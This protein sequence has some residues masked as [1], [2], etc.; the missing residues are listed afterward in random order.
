[1]KNILFCLLQVL[2][3]HVVVTKEETDPDE[4][5]DDVYP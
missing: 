5:E 1:M 2:G 4:G 3:D